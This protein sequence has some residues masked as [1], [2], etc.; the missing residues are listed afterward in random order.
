MKQKTVLLTGFPAPRARAIL[1]ALV[2]AEPATRVVLLVHPDRF[3]EAVQTLA[4]ASF[5]SAVIEL[6]AGDP[7]ALDFGLSG[8]AYGELAQG[9]N[10][11]HAAYSI[12]DAAAGEDLAERVN[13]G[14]ARE[15]SEFARVAPRLRALSLYSSVFVSGQR[16]GLVRED[17]LEAGQTFRGPVERSL[18]IAERMLRRSEAPIIVLRA[19]HLLDGAQQFGLEALSAPYLLAALLSSAPSEVALPLLPRADAPLALTP[20]DYLGKFGVFAARSA[21]P[22]SAFHVLDPA[23]LPLRGFLSL[24][25]E[26]SGRKLEPGFN[27]SALTRA[28]VGNPAARLLPQNLLRIFEVL[29]SSA[30]YSTENAAALVARGAPACP[31]LESYLDPLLAHVRERIENGNLSAARRHEAPFLVA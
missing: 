27:P 31:P 1:F 12:T 14:A 4:Q 21:G 29:T 23:Q 24:V 13:L 25:A 18:A 17:E 30:E 10:E 26:R 9:V 20:V 16:S 5:S 28:L 8:V 15:L 2:A 22:G 7:A 6:L 11:L 19:G 3:D